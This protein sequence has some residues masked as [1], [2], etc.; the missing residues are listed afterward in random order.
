MKKV[1]FIFLFILLF[2]L[3]FSSVAFTQP[4][5]YSG[6][7]T[8]RFQIINPDT[9]AIITEGSLIGKYENAISPEW[10]YQ[11]DMV[12]QDI[13]RQLGFPYTSDTRQV[14]NV[15]QKI[16]WVRFTHN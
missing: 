11:E 12:K 5:V 10:R 4:R 16:I 1:T 3:V 2:S 9:F 8:V 14:N 6:S 7:Y 15:T 13:R